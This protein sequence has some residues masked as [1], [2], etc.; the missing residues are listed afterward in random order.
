MPTNKTILITGGAGFIGAHT[1]RRLIQDGDTVVIVDNFNDFYDPTLKEAR[2]THLLGDLPF[3]LYRVDI[4]DYDK[5]KAVFQK[6][7][8]DHIIH[9]A[10]QASVRYGLTHPFVY[11]S[12]NLL[13]SINLFELA[14]EFSIQGMTLASSSSVYGNAQHFPLK[15]E[16]NTNQPISLY[17]ATKKSLEV[18]AYSYH[19]LY[20]IPM[21]CLRFF[22]VYGPWGRPDMAPLLFTKAI[23]EN[24]PIDVFGQGKME[25]DFTFVDDI[26][27]GIMKAMQKNPAFEIYNL[28]QG[29][30]I[31]LMKFITIIERHCGE[32]TK[33]KFLPMQLGDVMKT[34]AD[35]Q[36]ASTQLGWTPN[37]NI[38]N[39]LE[40]LVRWYK[41]YVSI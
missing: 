5:L 37:T 15:E 24:Q 27:D 39:G 2:L 18:L 8:I 35:N 3:T 19:H 11:A 10:A 16:D 14:K 20:H 34:F 7:S 29:K 21:S 33:K 4:A 28:G 17:G 1:A 40:K 36:K 23:F 25:R 30:P 13:G 32:K 9:L 22:T 31:Q 41:E 26:V 38:A 12:S 6:H